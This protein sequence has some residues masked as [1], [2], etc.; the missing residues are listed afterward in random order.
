[1]EKLNDFL[2]KYKSS[3]EKSVEEAMNV[4][5]FKENIEFMNLAK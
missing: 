5:E 2:K 3:W 4:V 1:L